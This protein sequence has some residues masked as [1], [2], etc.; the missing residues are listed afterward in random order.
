MSGGSLTAL[1]IVEMQRGNLAA[2]IPTNLI[3]ITDGQ[4]VLDAELFNRG[5]KPAVNVGRSVSRVG[6]AAQTAAIRAVAGK[7]R[8]ELSQFEEVARFARFG[9]EVD[10]ATQRQIRRG[11]RLR[12]VLGQPA[13]QPLSL[14]AQVVV[15]LAATEGFLDDIALEDIPDLE[16]SLLAYIEAAR[17]EIGQQINRSGELTPETRESLTEAIAAYRAAWREGNPKT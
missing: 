2:Y 14:A 11:E 9:T 6:G 1:P 5:L 8:L 16:S 10:E 15:L 13:H 7:L 4:L 17:P 3:S 12:A